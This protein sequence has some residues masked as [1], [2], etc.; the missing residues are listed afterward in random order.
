MEA[1]QTW[2]DTPRQAGEKGEAASLGTVLARL[3][4]RNPPANMTFFRRPFAL[5]GTIGALCLLVV[6]SVRFMVAGPGITSTLWITSGVAVLAWLKGGR[7]LTYSVAFAALVFMALMAG[8]LILGNPPHRAIIFVGLN[9]LEIALAVVL[10]RSVFPRLDAHT[11]KGHVK[12]IVTCLVACLPSALLCGFLLKHGASDGYLGGVRIWWLGHGVGMLMVLAIGFSLGG[13]LNRAVGGASAKNGQRI[14]RLA[15]TLFMLAVLVAASL[16]VFH[17]SFLALGFAILPL[18]LLIAVRMR[19][20]GT[21]IGLLVVGVI[22]IKGTMAG[23]GPYH[24][25]EPGAAL[26]MAQMLILFGYAPVLVVAALLDERDALAE[27]ARSGRQ[28]AEEAS[29][30]KS[31][32]LANVA[33]EIKSPV[34]GIIGIAEMWASGHLGEVTPAQKDM[35]QMMVRTGRQIENLAHDLLDVSQAES[36]A[37]RIEL[38][39]TDV[40]GVL[41]DVSHT[42]SMMPEAAGLKLDIQVAE[43]GLKIMADSQRLTQIM[44]NLGSNAVKYGREGG[45]VRF[46]ATRREDGMIRLAVEDGGRGL[47]PEK[48]VQLFEPFNRLG[49]ERSSIEGHGIGLALSKRLAELQKGQM[50]VAS[51]QGHGASFWVE[52]PEAY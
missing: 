5:V 50:G 44:I 28:K 2:T 11:V 16:M 52:L 51:V 3:Y 31:R 10:L 33:H 22:A 8:E 20:L 37:V 40:A 48:Q 6:I 17:Y 39:P 27:R 14:G 19:V 9:L 1:G 35:A 46:I 41:H 12:L 45:F 42:V 7:G 21:A 47:T 29:A 15:E 13:A 32:L 26:A 36:G 38:R 49:L 34:G 24:N 43:S 25:M 23:S 30:A 4:G 18:L